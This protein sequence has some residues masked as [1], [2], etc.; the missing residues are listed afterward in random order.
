M[1]RESDHGEKTLIQ[2]VNSGGNFRIL[3]L[4]FTELYEKRKIEIERIRCAILPFSDGFL[5]IKNNKLQ[6]KSI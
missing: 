3:Q 5:I 1:F 2:S 4:F 6:G